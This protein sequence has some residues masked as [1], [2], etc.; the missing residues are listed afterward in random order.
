LHTLTIRY[1][2][3]KH[4]A[5]RKDDLW[6]ISLPLAEASRRLERLI[7]FTS[8][9]CNREKILVMTADICGIEKYSNHDSDHHHMTR[10]IAAAKSV[11]NSTGRV[12]FEH[13][14]CKTLFFLTA[15]QICK[16]F[17]NVSNNV[18]DF[19]KL[20]LMSRISLTYIVYKIFCTQGF[21]LHVTF[22]I[23]CKGIPPFPYHR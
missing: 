8:R 15:D 23:F 7:F 17:K 14:A 21:Q 3:V 19:N 4:P 13:S 2:L 11:L 9:D 1:E 22:N 5:Y 16:S 20:V 12:K 10:L 18:I 6:K